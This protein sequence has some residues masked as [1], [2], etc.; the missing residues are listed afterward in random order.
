MKK[1]PYDY[2]D[3]IIEICKENNIDLQFYKDR[4]KYAE[5]DFFLTTNDHL[6]YIE[7][8]TRNITKSKY[9]TTLFDKNKVK[10]Y[11][12]N[13]NLD[14]KNRFYIIFGFIKE[15][16]EC[17]DDGVLDYYYIRYSN[18]FNNYDEKYRA[19]EQKLYYLIPNDD[20]L[21]LDELITNLKHIS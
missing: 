13:K 2:E 3:E 6:I 5:I 15:D 18:L 4:G 16:G 11:I 9:P 20:L 7:L 12:K 1:T 19:E 21:P 10:F 14:K 17:D 8:K